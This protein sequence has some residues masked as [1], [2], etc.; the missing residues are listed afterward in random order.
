[1][2]N[3]CSIIISFRNEE[4][5]I[6]EILKR[7]IETFKNINAFDYEIIF[8]NDFSDDNSLE[9]LKNEVEN[10]DKISV[11]NMS[12]RFGYTQCVLAGLEN[13]EGNCALTIDCDLQDPPELI[14]DMIAEF[15]NG[16]DLVHTIRT[17]RF[18]ESKLKMLI[19]KIGYK[20][21]NFFSD[22]DLKTNVGDF[23]LFSRRAIDKIL[24]VG[25]YEPYLRGVSVWIGFK[26]VIIPY[27]RQ[28]RFSGSTHF[29]LLKFNSFLR[30]PLNEFLKG[31]TSF[32][33]GP[34]YFIFFN[35]L[36]ISFLSIIFIIY[37]FIIKFFN[38]SMTGVPGIII[39][40][41]FFFGILFLNMGIFG[42]YLAKIFDQTKNRPRYIIDNIIKKKNSK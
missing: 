33:N 9:I 24:K 20:I 32:S 31:L 1:M 17:K 37:G 38:L 22:I 42:L 25:D 40:I 27:E 23:R 4:K 5:N 36:I 29:S 18:G 15:N 26:Q 6:K 39:L 30:G 34:L 41:S 8:V 3:K 16:A 11:I 13:S 10:N 12:R 21:I 2:I 28:A 35:G 14:K 19:T 7:I